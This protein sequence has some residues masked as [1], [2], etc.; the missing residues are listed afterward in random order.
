MNS[1][2]QRFD[3]QIADALGC[4]GEDEFARKKTALLTYLRATQ[5][6]M[7]S[8]ESGRKR[9]LERMAAMEGITVDEKLGDLALTG[10][11]IQRSF[12]SIPREQALA[13]IATCGASEA[14]RP[15]LEKI[16]DEAYSNI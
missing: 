11:L 7:F 12:R 5:P 4:A 13:A 8:L 10:Y 2:R 15:L 9:S 14:D 3:R 1:L 6:G 16:I